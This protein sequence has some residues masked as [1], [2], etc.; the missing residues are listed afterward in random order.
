MNSTSLHQTVIRAAGF[1]FEGGR[2]VAAEEI[3]LANWILARQNR[4]K[5]FVFFPTP[6]DEEDGLRLLSGEKP[7][8]KLLARNALELET[9]RLLALIEPKDAA[10]ERL[11]QEVGQRLSRL[12]FAQV[13][14][15]G[16]C[17]HASI[18]YLRYRMAAGG[19]E[20]TSQFEHGLQVLKQDRDGDGRWRKFPFWF[21]LL[22]LVELPAEM[23]QEELAYTRDRC[24]QLLIEDAPNAAPYASI[25][26]K[27][28][29]KAVSAV[30]GY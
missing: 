6:E 29:H 24:K 10:V 17:A 28:L 27:I 3:Q 30:Y 2:Y 4:Q 22:W 13:C 5:G 1:L 21:T 14:K 11:Q 26:K 25:R 15:T 7:R 19:R 12:C 23:A 20:A 9:L 16:E 18:A 8:T